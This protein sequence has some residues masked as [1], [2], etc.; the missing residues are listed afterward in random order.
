M[1]ER[2]QEAMESLGESSM[3]LKILN[4]Q[5]NTERFGWTYTGSPVVSEPVDSPPVGANGF[6]MMRYTAA[7]RQRDFDVD[8]LDKLGYSDQAKTLRANKL[9]EFV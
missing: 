5:H 4:D 2:H 1:I 8:M 3:A 6:T 9:A 7:K